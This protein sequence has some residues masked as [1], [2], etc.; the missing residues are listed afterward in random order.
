MLL[1]VG[2]SPLIVAG[3]GTLQ[4]ELIEVAGGTNV[5]ADVGAAAGRRSSH[6]LVIARAPEVIL[7]AAM[8]TGGRR[9]RALRWAHDR[10]PRS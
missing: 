9:A 6:E 10:C 7:D 5:A 3:G 2:H 4:G 1:V 8:G